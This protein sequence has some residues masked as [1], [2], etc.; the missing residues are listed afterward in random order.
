V[1]WSRG[2]EAV[3][4]SVNGETIALRSTT[5][6]PPGARVD[7]MLEV[8]PPVRLR[9]K[10]HACRRQAEG[11]FRLEGRCIDMT[12]EVREKLSAHAGSR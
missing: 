12:R 3:V 7:G 6:A 2:G 5:A 4:E 9:I 10:V 8:E 1:R 11:D